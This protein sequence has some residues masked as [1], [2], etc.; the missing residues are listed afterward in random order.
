MCEARTSKSTSGE[1]HT[2]VTQFNNTL[3]IP[4]QSPSPPL[5]SVNAFNTKL[6]RLLCRVHSLVNVV[7]SVI[8]GGGDNNIATFS[9][10]FVLGGG[11]W[12][13]PIS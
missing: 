13:L 8:K 5:R 6:L 12:V 4:R 2:H 10:V 3:F 1:T 9:F 7:Q 11:G